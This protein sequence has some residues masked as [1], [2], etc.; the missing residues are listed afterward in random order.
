[1]TQPKTNQVANRVKT[2]ELWISELM[3]NKR[4]VLRIAHSVDVEN[5]LIYFEIQNDD[6]IEYYQSKREFSYQTAYKYVARGLYF[7]GMSKGIT[8]SQF[9]DW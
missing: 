9:R 3:P 7:K 1:M 6:G 8:K 4:G 2:I 5:T